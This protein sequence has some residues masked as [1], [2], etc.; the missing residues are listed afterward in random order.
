M[1]DA[2]P[3]N[4]MVDQRL[5]TPHIIDFA[6][7]LFRDEPVDQWHRWEWQE[8]EDWDPDVEYWER[9]SEQKDLVAIGLVAGTRVQKATGVKLDFAFPDYTK[10][11]SEVQRRKAEAGGTF[12]GTVEASDM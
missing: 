4:V 5:Q 6:Q 2:S 3:R 1:Q 8:D 7:C 12:P 11:I 9:A 10:I